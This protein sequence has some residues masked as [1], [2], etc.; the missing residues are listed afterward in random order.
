MTEQFEAV[1]SPFQLGKFTLKNRIVMAPLTRQSAEEDGTPTDEMAAYWA[2]RARG[3]VSM[4][5]TEGTYENDELG[6]KAYLSQPGCAN[7]KHVAG[8]KKTVD[9]VHELGVPIILQLMHGGR[10]TDPRCLF[11]GE[12]PVTASDGQSPGAVLYTDSD[13]EKNDRGVTGDWPLVTFP[14]ARAATEAEI[15]RIAEGFAEGSVR[16]ID[17]HGWRRRSSRIWRARRPGRGSCPSTI[18]SI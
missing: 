3:G 11:E 2:R 10:V 15:E 6:C 14:P 7:D 13:D 18:L 12:E 9:A 1:F 16:A 5:I 17:A 4:I 8:W